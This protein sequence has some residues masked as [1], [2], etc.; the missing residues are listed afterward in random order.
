LSLLSYNK[1]LIVS[2]S[3]F[4]AR[5]ALPSAGMVSRRSVCP[6]VRPFVCDAGVPYNIINNIVAL[7]SCFDSLFNFAANSKTRGHPLKL[8]LPESR[9]V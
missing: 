6:S 5:Y 2:Y 4:A 9:L 1:T 8:T 3:V 7:A